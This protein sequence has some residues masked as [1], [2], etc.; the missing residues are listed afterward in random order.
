MK[1][2]IS[3]IMAMLF[4]AAFGMASPSSAENSTSEKLSKKD[5]AIVSIAAF[6]ANSD[7]PKLKNALQL[8]LDDGLTVNEIKEMLVQI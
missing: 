1:T 2:Q 8:G 4:F 6:T 5:K 3:G 7:I